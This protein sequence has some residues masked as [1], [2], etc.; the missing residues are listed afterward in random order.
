MAV[1]TG[2]SHFEVLILLYTSTKFSI[3]LLNL[4]LV[5]IDSVN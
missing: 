1:Y 2:V 5:S 3:Y 4:N